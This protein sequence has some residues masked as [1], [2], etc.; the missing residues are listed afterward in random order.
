MKSLFLF[1][2][3]I[4]LSVSPLFAQETSSI[5][6]TV[7]DASGAFIPEATVTAINVATQFRRTVSTNERGEYVASAL[8][9]GKYVITAEK[10]GFQKLE[11]S[12]ITLTTAST[13]SVGLKLAIGSENQ[14]VSV[15][16]VA[17]LLQ[18]QSGVVSSLVDSK[19]IVDLP[20][21]SRNFTDLV[22]LTPGAH[23]GSSSNLAEG[24][25]AYSI[26]GGANFSVNG[27]I[28]AANSYLIDGVYDRN[29]WLNT[30]VMV[31]VE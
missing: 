17:S 23:T 5:V 1:L 29:L 3:V 10:E 2:F 8:P 28:A 7:S 26:R 9:T 4:I 30:L 31:P 11:R 24:G 6:G 20:L 14:T 21:A 27:S 18:S 13:L 12:G 15:T 16:A 22:L 19:Q 25:S